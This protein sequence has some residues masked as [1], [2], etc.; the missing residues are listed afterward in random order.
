MREHHVLHDRQAQ[1]GAAVVAA[2]RLV[3]P[4]EPV[5]DPPAL[6]FGDAVAVVA[7]VEAQPLVVLGG[8][9][10]RDRG[11]GVPLRVVEQVPDGARQVPAHAEDREVLLHV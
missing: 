3:E 2:A 6:A 5:E 7:D 1:P 9:G 4:H 11:R 8:E 10:H